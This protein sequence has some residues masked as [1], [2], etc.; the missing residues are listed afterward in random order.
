LPTKYEPQWPAKYWSGCYA[1][2]RAHDVKFDSEH[3]ETFKQVCDTL[4]KWSAVLRKEG[5]TLGARLHPAIQDM[6]DLEA[7]SLRVFTEEYGYTIPGGC[8]PSLSR[9]Y[10][11][12]AEGVLAN[13]E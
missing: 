10:S 5:V 13:M 12:V 7:E 6:R 4:Q 9:I 8:W 2:L 1:R 3:L 11:L